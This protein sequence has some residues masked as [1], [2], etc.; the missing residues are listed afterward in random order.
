[1]VTATSN[2][3]LIRRMDKRTFTQ[4]SS[5]V[6]LGVTRAQ[7]LQLVSVAGGPPPSAS[8]IPFCGDRLAPPHSSCGKFLQ[9]VVAAMFCELFHSFPSLPVP[10]SS[11]KLRYP[12][13][14]S[15]L[16]P[17]LLVILR[18]CFAA[19]GTGTVTG[20]GNV[21]SY[22]HRYWHGYWPRL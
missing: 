18:R 13:G 16:S 9:H 1:M 19:T 8:T 7:E 5:D 17:W 3:K 12:L 20:T 11:P 21:H 22:W 6:I 2:D 4:S 10:S 15:P 14:I